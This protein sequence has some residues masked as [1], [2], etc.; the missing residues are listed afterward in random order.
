MNHDNTQ[1]T[2]TYI[3]SI[4]I[5]LAVGLFSA[6]LTRDSMDLYGQLVMPPLAPPSGWSKPTTSSPCQQW[7]EMGLAEAACRAAS[8]STPNC[9]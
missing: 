6:L 3:V 8:T 2:K 9:A 1:R 7:M 5:A 4:A